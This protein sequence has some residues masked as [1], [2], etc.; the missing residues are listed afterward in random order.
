MMRPLVLLLALLAGGQAAAAPSARAHAYLDRALDLMQAHSLYRARLDWAAIRA[1]T[2]AA[3]GDAVSTADT[4]PALRHGLSLLGD[5]HSALIT[6][7]RPQP[8]SANAV[9]G[10][11]ASPLGALLDGGHA[12][13]WLPGHAGGNAAADR[14]YADALQALVAEFAGRAACGWV[15]DLRD[16]PGG[17]MWPMLAGLA[18]LLGDGTVGGFRDPDGTVRDW[19]VADGAAGAAGDEHARSSR[20]FEFER[21]PPVAVLTGPGTASSGEAV[22]VAFEGRPRS[23]SFG[24]ATF[25]VPTGNR[26]FR[27]ADGA[28]MFVTASRFV[29]RDGVAYDG[30]IA[31]DRLAGDDP[32]ATA[33][34]WL[35]GQAECR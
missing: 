31:P 27:L 14:A 2:V 30:P 12:Y 19:W 18:A 29:D 15:V 32:L 1:D 7:P 22:R 34:G 11:S 17:N 5:R 23:R 3:A 21:L 6:P 9:D 26:G 25:G 28:L 20:P 24:A 4:W 13:L 8:V 10:R 33:R 35:A 16:N